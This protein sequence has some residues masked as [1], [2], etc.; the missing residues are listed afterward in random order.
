VVIGAPALRAAI[1]D[2]AGVA[3]AAGD[4]L[5]TVDDPG[6]RDRHGAQLP[7]VRIEGELAIAVIAPALEMT[8]ADRADMAI[9]RCDRLGTVGQPHDDHRR[10]LEV[11]VLFPSWPTPLSPQHWDRALASSAQVLFWPA[12]I[13]I[14]PLVNPGTGTGERAGVGPAGPLPS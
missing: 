10:W 6:D 2:R 13:A 11:R 12:A 4:R 5:C 1:D 9:P 8:V 7:A 14:T 3:I